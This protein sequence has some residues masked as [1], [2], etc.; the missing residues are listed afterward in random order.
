[1]RRLKGSLGYP[2]VVVVTLVAALV[3]AVLWPGDTPWILDEPGEVAI[4][5]RANQK[6]QL[7]DHG[8][9]G[10]FFMCYGP[11]PMHVYQAML[12]LSHDPRALVVMRGVL[13]SVM[14]AG[15][16]LWLGRSL[17]LSGWF[18]AALVLAPHLWF[19]NRNLWAASLAIPIGA[20]AVAAYAAYLREK[21]GRWLIL[22]LGAG[23]ALLFI[24]PQAAP[25]SAAIVW[26]M[27]W[28][29]RGALWR[30]RV[31]VLCVLGFLG[32]LNFG[33]IRYTVG[34]VYQKT[35]WSV[36]SGH[37]SRTSRAVS[38]LGPLM[39][40]RLFSGGD[41]DESHCHLHGPRVLMQ[42][43]R[44]LSRASI[45]LLWAGV[46]AGVWMWIRRRRGAEPKD[47]VVE[48]MVGIALAGLAMQGVYFGLLR[49]PPS[50]HYFFGMF[51]L[52]VVL[53]WV[54]VEALSRW[55]MREAVIAA[56]GI[57]LGIITLG[58]LWQV[59]RE[60]WAAGTMSPTLNEQIAVARELNQYSDTQAWTDVVCYQYEYAHALW[61]LRLL[62]PP[63]PN[64]TQQQSGRLVI[65]YR[66]GPNGPSNQIEVIEAKGEGDIPAN[67]KAVALHYPW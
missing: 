30:H 26:H 43:A 38:A 36:R 61:A 37:P 32:I 13:C 14:L 60:G 66:P 39:G 46:A 67:A 24:H 22:A 63:E 17:K 11:L 6:G 54:G 33:Y 7:A 23:I 53:A 18:A 15:S 12:L 64:Q 1:M 58:T 27:L 10:N 40:G 48:T 52:H 9:A 20:L 41:F 34:T 56:Y 25:L 29:E 62:F 2:L 5:F 47:A 50:T 8:L 16:L 4:A 45:P 42:T 44:V 49:V 59:H 35:G 57:S 31:G 51:A 21:A 19:N 3:P 28:R 55:R 65:R